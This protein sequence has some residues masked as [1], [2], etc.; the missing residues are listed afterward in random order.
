MISDAAAMPTAIIAMVVGSISIKQ[1]QNYSSGV[2]RAPLSVF[3]DR[4]AFLFGRIATL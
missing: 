2:A 3:H 1:I 4:Q